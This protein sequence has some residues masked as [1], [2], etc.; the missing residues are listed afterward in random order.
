MGAVRCSPDG[1][2]LTARGTTRDGPQPEDADRIGRPPTVAGY[3]RPLTGFFPSLRKEGAGLR[4]AR[5][6]AALLSASGPRPGNFSTTR[7]RPGYV[8]EEVNALLEAIRQTFLR[9]REPS[10]TTDEIRKKR[11]PGQP[12]CGLAMTRKRSTPS[13]NEVEFEASCLDMAGRTW[14]TGLSRVTNQFMGL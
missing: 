6:P 11:F 13:S 8:I 12:V 1:R 4:Q 14:R 5:K 10:L 2:A 9:R 3:R 7:L